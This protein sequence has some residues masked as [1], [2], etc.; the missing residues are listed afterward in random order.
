MQAV[1]Y[2]GNTRDDRLMGVEYL[3]SER[4]FQPLPLEEKELWLSP[5]TKLSPA[6][7]LRQAYRPRQRK[8]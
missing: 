8:G 5:R 4:L 7:L 1:I 3:I 2:G 6:R